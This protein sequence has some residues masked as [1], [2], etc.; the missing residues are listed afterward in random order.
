MRCRSLYYLFLFTFVTILFSSC[1]TV[2]NGSSHKVHFATNIEAEQITV[3]K[4]TKR[5]VDG[6]TTFEAD[7]KKEPL[8]V[9]IKGKDSAYQVSIKSRNTPSYLYDVI[10]TAGLAA[11]IG[12]E[13]PRRYGYRNYIYVEKKGDA[14][15]LYRFAPTPKG[16]V[17]VNFS[18]PYLNYLHLST[19]E[20]YKDIA[21]FFGLS[22]GVDYFYKQNT[23]LSLQGG[24]AATAIEAVP[25]PVKYAG[26]HEHA[27]TLF[28]S[29]RNNHTIRS[30][31]FGY[32]L[33]FSK[34]YWKQHDDDDPLF[35]TK[36]MKSSAMGLSLTTQ[37]RITKNF[38]MGF[39]YQPSFFT[40]NKTAYAN[41]DRNNFSYQHLLS[42]ELVF[43]FM[44]RKGM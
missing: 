27:S 7:R 24:A 36:E 6:G 22:A 32:G 29:I 37:Y 38:R 39:L 20:N 18:M 1:A 14:I 15:R 43:K 2:F 16:T 19:T 8:L 30:F 12:R 17:N 42:L 31:D 34:Y 44:A 3:N 13:D 28:A 4:R 26:K 21:G 5:L 25:V 41:S 35:A 40:L 10:F 9:S 23:Y 33:S 11:I